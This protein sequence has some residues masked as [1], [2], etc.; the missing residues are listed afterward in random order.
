MVDSKSTLP[1]IY[2]RDNYDDAF[3]KS[4][5]LCNDLL[6]TTKDYPRTPKSIHTSFKGVR[7]TFILTLYDNIILSEMAFS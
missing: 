4:K 1:K 2:W 5:R 3:Y 7:D 6:L